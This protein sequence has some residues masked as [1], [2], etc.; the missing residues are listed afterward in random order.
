[1]NP[2]T[3]HMLIDARIAD[4]R[5]QAEQRRLARLARPAS[6]H[7]AARRITG[8]GSALHQVVSALVTPRGQRRHPG[9]VAARAS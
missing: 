4:V 7:T 1:M 6:G 3:Q 9:T 2:Y 5:G 8:P